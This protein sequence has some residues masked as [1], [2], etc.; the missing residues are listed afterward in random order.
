MYIKM[1]IAPDKAA[2][3]EKLL[4]DEAFA[5]TLVAMQSAEEVQAALN[6]K[7]LD[8]SIEEINNLAKALN[9][10]SASDK[11]LTEE[12]LDSVAGGIYCG[13][14]INPRDMYYYEGKRRV[15]VIHIVW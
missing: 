8:L 2:L 4:S 1:D 9:E 13:P 12:E 15:W 3:L 5:S 7:G 14:I 10:A 11:D 6:A